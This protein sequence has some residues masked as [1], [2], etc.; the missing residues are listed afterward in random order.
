[1][2][3]VW[4]SID[5]FI[6]PWKRV[7]IETKEGTA[8]GAFAA[9]KTPERETFVQYIE[10]PL[11]HSI[12]KV[13]V[14]KGKEFPFETIQDLY[15]KIIGKNLGF[16]ISEEF[17]KAEAENMIQIDEASTMEQNIQKLDFGRVDG[18]V[19]NEQEVLYILQQRGFSDTI[20]PLARPVREPRPAYLMISNAAF[21]RKKDQV[22]KKLSQ[23]LHR[24]KADGAFERIY[25][26]Y[27][28]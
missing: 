26:K 27:G 10:P 4:K 12:Y 6:N 3:E 8:D 20:V 15:G 18:V 2:P 13:F 24:M 17:A 7:I 23:T 14:K 16:H 9:F 21:I 1:M 28:K 5:Y 11:H 22:I 25:A 19:G